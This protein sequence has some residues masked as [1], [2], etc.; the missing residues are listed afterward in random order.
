MDFT[1]E[2]SQAI[3]ARNADIL[4]SA[5]AGSGKTAVL[6]ERIISII[7]DVEND[8][9][10]DNLLIVTFTELAGKEMR[11]RLENK[12]ND[13]LEL[14]PY[15]LN[16][17][18][19]L[20]LLNRAN[21][22]TIH[23]FCRKIIMQNF[24][25]LEIDTTF[26]I[27]DDLEKNLIEQEVLDQVLEEY[28][29]LEDNE[30]FR[31][32][33]EMYSGNIE[34]NGFRDVIYNIYKN[35]LNHPQPKLWINSAREIHNIKT[36]ENT[37][38]K[39]YFFDYTRQNL[40]KCINICKLGLE[41]AK[42]YPELEKA[43]D[44]IKVELVFY[45]ELISK[46]EFM[47]YDELYEVL[48]TYSH[49]RYVTIS[50][51]TL[52]EDVKEEKDRVK[53][54]RDLAKDTFKSIG[55]IFEEDEKSFLE[56]INYILPY[57]EKLSEV[58]IKYSEALEIEKNKLNLLTFNDL[59]HL[60]IRVLVKD[61]E[62]GK[63]IFSDVS[64]KYQM[65][66]AEIIIDEYQDTNE[67]QDLILTAVSR[68][69]IN[70]PN[71]FMVGDVKQS[72]YKF[73]GGDPKLFIG[74]Y[75]S[76]THDEESHYR[77]I[78]LSKNFRSSKS[79][80]QLVNFVFLQLMQEDVGGIKY[81][82]NAMLHLGRL[83]SSDT[84]TE[85]LLCE[86]EKNE[87]FSLD[88]DSD[89]NFDNKAEFEFEVI[90][91]RIFD[92]TNSENEEKIEY[93]DIAILLRSR[94]NIDAL[95]R[96]LKKYNIPSN[97]KSVSNF[98]DNYEVQ[99]I[100]AYLQLI[101]NSLQDL[102]V[103]IVLKSPIYDISDD[104]LVEIA[105]VN[106]KLHFIDRI[107]ETMYLSDNEVLKNKLGTFLADYEHFK[108]VSRDMSISQFILHLYDKTEIVSIFQAFENGDYMKLNLMYLVEKAV[109]FEKTS[110][111]TIFNFVN[112]IEKSKNVEDKNNAKLVSEVNAVNIMTI[113]E[114][115][116]LEF[117]VVF[118]SN[119][120][121]LFNLRDTYNNIITTYDI[122]FTSK[123]LDIETRVRSNTLL[124]NL[125]A[126]NLKNE[127]IAEELRVFYV[128]LTR[129]REKL[130]LTSFI[131][132]VDKAKSKWLNRFNSSD[133]EAFPTDVQS[134]KSY[135][136]FLML[137]LIA[138]KSCEFISETDKKISG[139]YDFDL[140]IK[141]EVVNK[142]NFVP[143]EF[144]TEVIQDKLEDLD[145]EIM[146]TTYEYEAFTKLP[147]FTTISEI[148]RKFNAVAKDDGEEDDKFKK[149][150]VKKEPSFLKDEVDPTKKGTAVHKV[151]E[152]INFNKV[153]TL[154]EIKN[155][156]LEMHL[157]NIITENELKVISAEK[158]VG[159]FES[160]LF[161]RILRSE[162][163][164]KEQI[165]TLGM[166]IEEIYSEIN[167]NKDLDNKQIV[168]KGMIDCFFE[169][170]D[171]YVLIDFKTDRV[172]KNNCKD[173]AENY[174][175][176]LDL[177]SKAIEH[178]LDKPVKEKY[179]YFYEINELYLMD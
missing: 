108:R 1:N 151:F 137:T 74:K 49:G 34:D 173:V 30:I 109:D 29:S 53:A 132:S 101:D 168:V 97:S 170:E 67:V 118:V 27:A 93:K 114:S 45:E 98:Y 147:T 23:S 44:F 57:I 130:I 156:L 84:E 22:S 3:Y 81:D 89:L 134:C 111:T 106:D 78:D 135:L 146:D 169:D 18:K 139:I 66:F 141:I 35:S 136:D 112:Y 179:I 116:G 75:N 54:Y 17:K 42:K 4:V 8:I 102:P 86:F 68:N 178:S 38:I 154:E 6:V 48:K 91:K 87:D 63:A 15:D 177:Y 123:V 26:R 100:L 43:Y 59:E 115:K 165:F 176:Q 162:K 24:T 72:I 157:K 50:A 163:I 69:S 148:K 155:I 133:T 25:E 103:L 95:A 60:A 159:F 7:T 96:I 33:L 32:L 149:A 99:V 36:I 104:E 143:L 175:I 124:R 167:V 58:V 121:G 47:T 62:D 61:F 55:D 39:D 125:M 172:T 166:P 158:L 20:V 82:E 70:K 41:L 79:V 171:G 46:L 126:N 164:F 131:N 12:L 152:Y 128:A 161:K 105:M 138:H 120:G 92:I 73:R 71:K 19:Q 14:N 40:T 77:K 5:A 94:K 52:T 110:F 16:L 11:K 51:K 65:S 76:Y 160:R 113:H 127:I 90:A 142:G 119:L 117:P 9:N 21:I 129:A 150:L 144:E 37:F 122:P 28:Y 2:Q 85:V 64:K 153:Y 80:I 56:N 31:N 145:V 174:R 88:E 107:T 13:L 140:P 10:V 83:E